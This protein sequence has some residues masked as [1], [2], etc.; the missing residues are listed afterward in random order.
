[1]GTDIQAEGWLGDYFE[2]YQRVLFDGDIRRRIVSFR[3]LCLKVR[4][5]GGKLLLAGNG[6]SAS[7]SSHAATD[8]TKQARVKAMCFNDANLITALANDYGYENWISRA[9]SSYA[10][11]GDVVVLISSSGRSS[12]VVNAAKTSREMSLEVV[13]F[14]GFAADN[15][16]SQNG[17]LDF[18]VDSRA[19]NIIENTHSIWITATIDLII[20]K[21]E[22]GV[23]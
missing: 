3:D 10:Q 19:Y 1:M 2:R 16:L 5:R 15:P 23:S 18:W 6:A 22:Y 13:T 8:F 9:I 14:T 20:G 11:P 17:D 7:I 21:A 12:N 4:D